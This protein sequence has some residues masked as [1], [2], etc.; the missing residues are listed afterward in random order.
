MVT[1]GNYRLHNE[2]CFEIQGRADDSSTLVACVYRLALSANVQSRTD[3]RLSAVLGFSFNLKVP[4]ASKSSTMGSET[5]STQGYIDRDIVCTTCPPM[6]VAPGEFDQIEK[7]YTRA[8]LKVIRSRIARRVE[9]ERFHRDPFP[10]FSASRRC[11]SAGCAPRSR[12]RQ[13]KQEPST[14]ASPPHTRKDS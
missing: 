5:G 14:P 9:A 13:R 12:A 7:G 4:T 11:R 10:S 2:P 1:A 8:F 3:S 6:A